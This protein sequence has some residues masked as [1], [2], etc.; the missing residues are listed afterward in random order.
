MIRM[1][2]SSFLQK[3]DHFYSI[4]CVLRNYVV[5]VTT[6]KITFVLEE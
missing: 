5:V 6:E 2:F 4:L 1:V 3:N